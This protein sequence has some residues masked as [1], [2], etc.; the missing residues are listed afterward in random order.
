MRLFS[1]TTFAFVMAICITAPAAAFQNLD[2]EGT[3]LDIGSLPDF[4]AFGDPDV[5]DPDIVTPGWA[6]RAENLD[7]SV[8]GLTCS[9]N[10]FCYEY[11]VHGA[12]IDGHI[13]ESSQVIMTVNGRAGF[14][15]QVLQGQ[16]SLFLFGDTSGGGLEKPIPVAYQTGAVPSDAKSVFLQVSELVS[17]LPLSRYDP[18]NSF[19]VR[20]N[21]Y[22]VEMHPVDFIPA[23]S[24]PPASYPSD[25][26]AQNHFAEISGQPI[27]YPLVDTSSSILYAGNIEPI[28]GLVR[29]LAIRPEPFYLAERPVPG[30][31]TAEITFDNIQF[32]TLAAPG[33]AV[34]VP[35]PATM[36]LVASGS[37]LA[38]IGRR[39]FTV[40]R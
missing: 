11:P 30:F 39:R 18:A 20:F 34:Q 7:Y 36:W 17:G 21:G 38:M 6:Y 22:E 14:G 32:S 13:G 25:W 2:F 23:E 8:I 3:L 9:F 26:M 4:P 16:H 10:G 24:G 31:T 5:F 29:E 33:P 27:P 37:L 19:S 1:Q 40:W 12:L 35:E 28:A 15:N